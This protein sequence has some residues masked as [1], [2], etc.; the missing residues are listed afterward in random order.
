MHE[1]VLPELISA[2]LQNILWVSVVVNLTQM[3]SCLS[4]IFLS[5]NGSSS[6]FRADK[7]SSS[8]IL[9][10]SF[11]FSSVHSSAFELWAHTFNM[12]IA[13]S[14]TLYRIF[15]TTHSTE[16]PLFISYFLAPK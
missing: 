2:C 14:L 1:L 11:S 4:P 13:S 9:F 16:Y 3:L 12:P 6:A 7:T 15:L 8:V 5:T 10:N